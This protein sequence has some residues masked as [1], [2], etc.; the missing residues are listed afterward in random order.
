MGDR[1]RIDS[2]FQNVLLSKQQFTVCIYREQEE[3]ANVAAVIKAAKSVTKGASD[4]KIE[5]SPALM[6]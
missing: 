4:Q 6:F 5:E 2:H 1:A 3:L